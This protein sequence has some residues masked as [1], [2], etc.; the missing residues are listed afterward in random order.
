MD[1]NPII[2][3]VS[4]IGAGVGVATFVDQRRHWPK[5]VALF[6]FA[7]SSIVE[8]NVK[9]IDAEIHNGGSQPMIAPTLK[10]SDGVHLRRFRTF[11]TLMP[12]EFMSGVIEIPH[13]SAGRDFYAEFS[14]LETRGR[15]RISLVRRIT[16]PDLSILKPKGSEWIAA[17][18]SE[19][20]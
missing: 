4:A 10:A 17:L 5:A 16:L 3:G 6:K 19:L 18:G 12:G 2:L 14:W 8:D 15:K 7:P 20:R 1:L 11:G 13:P 9:S